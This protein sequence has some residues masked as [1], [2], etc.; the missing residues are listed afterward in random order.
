[1]MTG[2]YWDTHKQQNAGKPYGF[3]D[4]PHNFLNSYR[5]SRHRALDYLKQKYKR[6]ADDKESTI[7]H[8]LKIQTMVFQHMG[9]HGLDYGEPIFPHN[10][11]IE[12]TE[13]VVSSYALLDLE[14]LVAFDACTMIRTLFTMLLREKDIQ[15]PRALEHYR[16]ILKKME[17]KKLRKEYNAQFINTIKEDISLECYGYLGLTAGLYA[18]GGDIQSLSTLLKINDFLISE[19]ENVSTLLE[20]VLTSISLQ[21]EKSHVEKLAKEKGIMR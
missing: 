6:L 2:Y 16:R 5:E 12:D 8:A 18:L 15:D 21:L 7:G 3:I 14:K 20:V 19:K 4:F 10:F 17:L 9:Q 1:M 13:P 11:T